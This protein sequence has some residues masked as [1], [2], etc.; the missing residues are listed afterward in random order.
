M[1]FLYITSS[2][3]INNMYSIFYIIYKYLTNGCITLESNCNLEVYI[4]F[5]LIILS[6]NNFL[7]YSFIFAGYLLYNSYNFYIYDN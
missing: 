2:I 1:F 5:N 6:F 4:I 7:N 3:T